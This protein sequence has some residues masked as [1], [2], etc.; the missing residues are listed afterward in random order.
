MIVNRQDL[1]RSFGV[2]TPLFTYASMNVD[3]DT[4]RL[5]AVGDGRDVIV[6]ASLKVEGRPQPV[7]AAVNCRKIKDLIKEHTTDKIKITIDGNKAVFEDVGEDAKI[8]HNTTLTD[9]DHI[10]V[11]DDIPN[12]PFEHKITLPAEEIYKGIKHIE[13]AYGKPSDGHMTL[14]IKP[15]RWLNRDLQIDDQVKQEITPDMCQAYDVTKDVVV[16]FRT[17]KIRAFL[18][19]ARDKDMTIH[20]IGSDKPIKITYPIADGKGEAAGIFAPVME[21]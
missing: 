18:S 16:K 9:P 11:P 2:L 19:P 10:F 12:Y 5:R 15:D 7:N 14:D 17:S 20:L 13:S 3:D 6:T 1:I 8:T 21:R 4:I